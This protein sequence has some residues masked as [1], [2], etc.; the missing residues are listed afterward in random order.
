MR[1]K[2]IQLGQGRLSFY[3]QIGGL[4]LPLLLG[5]TCGSLTYNP[6]QQ[7]RI[8]PLIPPMTSF[9]EGR[10]FILSLSLLMMSLSLSDLKIQ[11]YDLGYIILSVPF[12]WSQYKI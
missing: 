6:F 10:M 5:P 8:S 9:V 11:S 1:K 3:R 4:A 12:V 2:E 7:Y